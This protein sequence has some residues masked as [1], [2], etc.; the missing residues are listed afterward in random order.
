MK[1]TF[2]GYR[3]PN[4]QVGIRNQILIIAID[5]CAEG[6]AQA[7]RHQV[8]NCVIIT[9]HYTC[10]YAGNEELVNIM[11]GAALNP[12]VA[13][14]L[15]LNMGCGSIDPALIATPIERSGKPVRRLS[16][17]K[18]QGT[19]KT[20]RDGVALAKELAALA[21]AVPIEPVSLD[22]LLVGVKC[23]GSDT[24]SGIASNPAVGRAVDALIDAGASCVAGEL[25]ELIGCE[26][27]LAQAGR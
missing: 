14:V 24:S 6:I 26:E 22:K 18:N 4:G 13:G 17:I 25:I 21:A 19:R 3:R 16:I 27:I 1:Q 15:L 2:S 8:S 9:N 11:T 5:E 12:N 23:G 10:M 7:I 20:I